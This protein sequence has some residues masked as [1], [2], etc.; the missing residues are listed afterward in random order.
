MLALEGDDAIEETDVAGDGGLVSGSLMTS[1]VV[2][3]LGGFLALWEMLRLC[4]RP[5]CAGSLK[6]CIG[7]I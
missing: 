7:A 6:E 5:I 3:T 4:A 1:P 2:T